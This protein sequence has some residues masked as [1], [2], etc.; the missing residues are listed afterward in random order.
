MGLTGCH[1]MENDGIV[2]FY[3]GYVRLAE[4]AFR[5]SGLKSFQNREDPEK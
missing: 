1:K 2:G 3:Y 5:K 4:L